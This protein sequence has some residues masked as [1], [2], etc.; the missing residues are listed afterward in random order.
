MTSTVKGEASAK[1]GNVLDGWVDI[2]HERRSRGIFSQALFNILRKS[3]KL[4]L[5]DL[6]KA[7]NDGMTTRISPKLHSFC[8]CNY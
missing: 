3:E 1:S 2:T 6:Y 5:H 8:L 7:F 4:V